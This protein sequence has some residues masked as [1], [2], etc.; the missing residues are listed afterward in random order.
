MDSRR[1]TLRSIATERSLAH[2]YGQSNE[3]VVVRGSAH[4]E[5]THN[6][7]RTLYHFDGPENDKFVQLSAADPQRANVP[8]HN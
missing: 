1:L 8:I 4:I 3:H 6:T 2:M 5:R 7:F